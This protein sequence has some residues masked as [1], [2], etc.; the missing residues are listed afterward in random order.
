MDMITN[1]LLNE[2]SVDFD[3]EN[4]K[5]DLQ[6]EHFSNYSVASKIFKGSFQ[7]DDIHTGSGGDCAIDGLIIIVNGRLVLSEDEIEDLIEKNSRLDVEII[8]IQ[9]KTSSKFQSKEMISFI[10]GTRDFLSAKPAIVQNDNIAQKKSI[11]NYL[12][13]KSSYMYQSPSCKLYYVTTGRWLDDTNLIAVI[14]RGKEDLLATGIFGD[15]VIHPIGASEIQSLYRQTKNKLSSDI[16][17]ENKITLPNIEGVSQA[18][19]GVVPMSEYLKLIQD[20]NKQIHSIFDDNVRDFQ[21]NNTVNEKIKSTLEAKK[22]DLFSLLNNGVTIVASDLN[23]VGNK[24]TIRDY[25]VVNGCQT[26]HVLH[27]CQN[28]ENVESVLVPLKII[29][30]DNDDIKVNITLATNSQTEVKTEQLESLN[31]FQKKLEL[32][33]QAEKDFQLYYERRSQQYNSDPG[34]KKTQVISI[35]LQI[36]AFASMFL[37][38]PHF[39]SGYYGTIVKRFQNDIFVD[40]HKCAPYYVS[41]LALYKIEQFFRSGDLEAEYKRARYLLLYLVRLL[42]MGESLSMLNSAQIEKDC[43]K[44]KKAMIDDEE[45]FSLFKQAIEIFTSS[46]I[47]LNK[48]QYKAE[49]DRELV[50]KSYQN[51]IEESSKFVGLG[52]KP[53]KF[54]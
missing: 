36:K 38:S 15:V 8:F 2:F 11:W 50:L 20:E 48:K 17:F 6:F 33:Y 14:E 40:E 39:V 43:L 44:L 41:S 9:S 5:K 45:A 47:D 16:F 53:N 27:E 52:T 10:N 18:Y 37:N 49:N 51:F 42:V 28:I 31:A 12:I 3:I 13:S 7:I 54:T 1:A 35:P 32:Y 21:G 29:V 24:F 23:A 46:G 22:F 34:I 25:Q 30:T 26:S 4:K 19:L